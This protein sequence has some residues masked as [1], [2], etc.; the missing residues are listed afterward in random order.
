[1]KTTDSALVAGRAGDY[2]SD[3]PAHTIFL[4][5]SV[6]EKSTFPTGGGHERLAGL[7]FAAV[8][9]HNFNPVKLN[10]S[11]GDLQQWSTS[12]FSYHINR[13]AL[14]ECFTGLASLFRCWWR[15]EKQN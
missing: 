11:R 15:H 7:M 10:A 9:S 12:F 4:Q 1:M 3:Q 5:V 6:S 8:L 2:G 14:K 13:E